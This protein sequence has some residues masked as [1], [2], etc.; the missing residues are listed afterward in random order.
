MSN[1]SNR[2]L[3][4]RVKDPLRYKWRQQNARCRYCRQ[5]INYDA[6]RNHPESLEVCHKYSVKTHPQHAYDPTLMFPGHSK[7]NRRAQA[8]TFEEKSWTP[9]NWG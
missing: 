2:S 4:K 7:C 8:E 6:P 3:E 1:L 5:P 9:A